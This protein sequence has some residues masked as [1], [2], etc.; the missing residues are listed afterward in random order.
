MHNSIQYGTVE[1]QLNKFQ[2]LFE[3]IFKLVDFIIC[4]FPFFN[5]RIVKLASC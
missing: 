4:Y 5:T 2:K 3:D 1:I